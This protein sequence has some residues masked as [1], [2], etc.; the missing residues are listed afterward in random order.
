MAAKEIELLGQARLEGRPLA[1][2]GELLKSADSEVGYN[3]QTKLAAWLTEHGQGALAGYKIGATTRGM[4]KFLGVPGPVYGHILA[5]KMHR[6]SETFICNPDCKP[7]VECEIAFRMGEDL[8]LSMSPFS[9]ADVARRIDA[10]MPAVEIVENRYGDF[11]ACS[12]ALLTADDFFHKACVMGDAVT[13]WSDLD[14]PAVVGRLSI[15]GV[16]METGLGREVFG[17]PLEVVV[18][19]ANKLAQRQIGLK[20]GQIIMT[21]S[22]TPVH[23]IDNYPCQVTID[24]AGLGTSSVNLTTRP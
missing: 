13:S 10:A 17:H 2:A 1:S 9:R 15:D 24:I 8:P 7:G 5:D 20:A 12:I 6:T 14:L 19:L 11:S 23:W 16:W 3:I 21:G 4:Q 18:W 22:M